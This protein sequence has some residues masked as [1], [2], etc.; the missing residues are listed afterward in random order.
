MPT[1]TGAEDLKE[2][3]LKIESRRM[4]FIPMPP[5]SVREVTYLAMGLYAERLRGMLLESS[6]VKDDWSEVD[7]EIW[8]RNRKGCDNTTIHWNTAMTVS[9]C[10]P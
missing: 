7:Q 4:T 6:Y 8:W 9:L 2:Q 3:Y 1:V 5:S 10:A